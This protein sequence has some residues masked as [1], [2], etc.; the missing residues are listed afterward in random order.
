MNERDENIEATRNYIFEGM[1]DTIGAKTTDDEV[2]EFVY[3]MEAFYDDNGADED[4]AFT[5]DASAAYEFVFE[6]RSKKYNE[7]MGVA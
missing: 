1:R 7:M 4:G 5:F 6:Y 2:S 3:E